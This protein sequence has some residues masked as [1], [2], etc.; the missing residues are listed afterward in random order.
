[1]V[2]VISDFLFP[3]GFD[4]GLSYLQWHNHDVYC[5]QVQSDEDTRCD[6]KGDV[7]LECVET[8]QR[9]RLTITAREAALYEQTVADWNQQLKRSCASRGIGL[10]AT[11]PE[12]PFDRVIQDILRR[13][14]LVA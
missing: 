9:H 11:T 8:A 3:D 2:I 4:E 1:V 7:E 5:L 6:W 13:G 12:I 10:A 14:G